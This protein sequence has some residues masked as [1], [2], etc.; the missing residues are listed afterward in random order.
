MFAGNA[1]RVAQH[2]AEHAAGQHTFTV[3]LNQFADLTEE[4]IDRYK[5]LRMDANS[6]APPPKNT[7]T[8]TN[9]V[10]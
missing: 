7:E 6:T 5:G 1:A 10:G 8:S 2:M 9:Q 4:E 3:A